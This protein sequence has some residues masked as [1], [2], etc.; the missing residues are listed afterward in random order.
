[1]PDPRYPTEGDPT[2]TDPLTEANGYLW[3]FCDLIG[4]ALKPGGDL[5]GVLHEHLSFI[6]ELIRLVKMAQDAIHRASEGE[7]VG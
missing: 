5:D 3:A 6:V 7:N 4:E 1:M 2:A